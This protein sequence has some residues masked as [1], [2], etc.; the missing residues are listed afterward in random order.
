M[1]PFAKTGGLADVAG[2]L[3][4]ALGRLGIEV[5]VLMPK[6]RGIEFSEKRLSDHV[7]VHFI[8][9]EPFFNRSG[10]Y[11]HQDSDYADNL[12]RFSYF[13][14]ECL[15]AAKRLGFKPDV[16]HAHDWHA[17]LIPVLLKTEFLADDFFKQTKSLLTIHNLA[18][19][20]VFA[21]SEYKKIGLSQE[22]F[23]VAGFEFYGM[24]NLLKA[25]LLFADRLN[26]VS[27]AY[28]KEIQ[29]VEFGCGLEGVLRQ[30]KNKLSGILNGIDT[31]AWNPAT[32]T[33]LSA[34]YSA[35]SLAGKKICKASLQKKYGLEVNPQ[36]P[37]LAVVSRL[38]HQKGLDLIAQA[39][40][41][42]ISSPLQLVILG[43]GDADYRRL[44]ERLG[45]DYP[46]QVKV[47][48]GFQVMAAHEIYAGAD[49]FLMPSQF[50]PCGLGQLIS[51][52]YGT[53]PVVRATGGLKDTVIDADQDP[54]KGNGFSFDLFD[55]KS[56]LSAVNR[57][58]KA[59]R[60]QERWNLLM[61]CAMKCNF[62]WDESAKKYEQLYREAV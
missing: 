30:R 17:S 58:M 14:R 40:P 23:S 60:D 19:Q 49:L 2:S 43:D 54:K 4:L 3:P 53:I 37:L 15:T 35:E 46:A 47:S 8:E 26:T 29:T 21:A 33:K 12:D 16:A 7:Q 10:L 18:Y 42:L 48:L 52:R 9:H 34:G 13:S 50:E 20:G 5:M 31:Q 61:T 22:L 39:L 36:I 28:A 38:A 32:D 6:Y 45:R 56:F 27:P 59:Y 25:G 62:S 11:G 44:F 1:A 51:M 41:D 55:S 57:A 24:V